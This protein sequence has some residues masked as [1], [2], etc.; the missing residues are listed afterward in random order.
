MTCEIDGIGPKCPVPMFPK[1]NT[2]WT[3]PKCGQV[4]IA[5][6]YWRAR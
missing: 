2:K 4:W 5:D 3:C 1:P 6:T